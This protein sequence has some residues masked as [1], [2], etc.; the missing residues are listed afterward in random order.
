MSLGR[1]VHAE[2]E[3]MHYRGEED[4]TNEEIQEYFDSLL[5]RVY[6]SL[7]FS[8]MRFFSSSLPARLPDM[9]TFP[10]DTYHPSHF[11]ASPITL[12][13]TPLLSLVGFDTN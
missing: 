6:V 7:Q 4:I 9:V 11:L 13:Q 10:F 12:T 1:K 3:A 8:S 2:L 5:D